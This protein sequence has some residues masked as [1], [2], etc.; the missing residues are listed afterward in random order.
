MDFFTVPTLTF[1]VLNCFFVISHDR[2]KILHFNVT[3]NPHA[4]SIVQQLREAWAYKQPHRFLLFDRDAKFGADVVSAVKE[5][6][7][8]PTRTAFGSP[9]QNGV[10]ER[11]VGNCRRDSLDHV[12][13]VNERHLKRLMSSYLLYYHEDRTHLGLARTRQEVV[14]QKFA[15]PVKARFNPFRDSAGCTI[16]TQWQRRLKSNS[17]EDQTLLLETRARHGSHFLRAFFAGRRISP[18]SKTEVL[19]SSGEK[20]FDTG[21]TIWRTTTSAA[22]PKISPGVIHLRMNVS[23][24]EFQRNNAPGPS[25]TTG[26]R[27]QVH[28]DHYG[29]GVTAAVLCRP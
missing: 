5:M 25:T 7:S 1:G 6:G 29:S 21:A 9:W 12:I 8:E 14:Q 22:P 20:S 28:L 17:S 3:R 23:H 13:V 18:P 26:G 24:W 10:A 2:R 16:A 27:R 11:W 4:L 19:T 15:L